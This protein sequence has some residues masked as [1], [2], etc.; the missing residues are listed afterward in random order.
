MLAGKAL[1]CRIA[2]AS[3]RAD[4]VVEQLA[5]A[6]LPQEMAHEQLAKLEPLVLPWASE[7]RQ[8]QAHAASRGAEALLVDFD[9]Q[10]Q[11]VLSSSTQCRIREPIVN[12]ELV[13]RQAGTSSNVCD[14]VELT[15]ADLDSMLQAC[16]GAKRALESISV[17]PNPGAN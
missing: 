9:W 15:A 1:V 8:V 11:L 6:G 3:Y 7:L 13:S 10:L 4:A 12:L 14:T 5:V 2:S 16:D 17:L